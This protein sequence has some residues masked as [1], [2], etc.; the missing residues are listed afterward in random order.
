MQRSVSGNHRLPPVR[1][2]A[3]HIQKQPHRFF[4]TITRLGFLLSI[5]TALAVGIYT[6]ADTVKV[7]MQ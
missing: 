1:Q 6:W 7:R 2:K 4:S 3:I 5:F